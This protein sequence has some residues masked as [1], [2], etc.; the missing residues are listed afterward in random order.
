MAIILSGIFAALLIGR[1]VRLALVRLK[2]IKGGANS[3]NDIVLTYVITFVVISLIARW[4][5][6]LFM[7]GVAAM[8]LYDIA[9]LKLSSSMR[10]G[11]QY[12]AEASDD[13]Y[14]VLGVHE[15]DSTEKIRKVYRTLQ[16]TYHPDKHSADSTQASIEQKTEKIKQI[17]A[18]FDWIMKHR[19]M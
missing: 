4:Q 8:I 5:A 10:A 6:R 16:Q 18:A 14:A 9:M 13:P 1:L 12:R 2:I 11:T 7:P 17:N 15:N 19:G 3:V